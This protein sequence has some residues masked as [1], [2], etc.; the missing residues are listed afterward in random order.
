ML[1]V[2]WDGFA[3]ELL[4]EVGFLCPRS[5]KGNIHWFTSLKSL[6]AL[7]ASS[8]VSLSSGTGDR[9]CWCLLV[10]PLLL[11]S[12]PLASQGHCQGNPTMLAR[13]PQAKGPVQFLQGTGLC[14]H[15]VAQVVIKLELL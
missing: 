12:S 4:P 9:R 2:P 14:G 3:W 10:S 15:V 13:G 8:S 6:L 1:P 7:F 5:R 11:F